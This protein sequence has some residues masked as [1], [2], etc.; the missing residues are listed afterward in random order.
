[1]VWLVCWLAGSLAWVGFG[2]NWDVEVETALKN[3]GRLGRTEVSVRLDGIVFY[4]LS[5][6]H[7][8]RGRGFEGILKTLDFLELLELQSAKHHEHPRFPLPLQNPF[9]WDHAQM[10]ERKILCRIA[11]TRALYDQI[12]P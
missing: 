6:G 4:A 2:R 5:S 7:G 8:P 9:P 12:R 3:M 11:L 10:I 1:M